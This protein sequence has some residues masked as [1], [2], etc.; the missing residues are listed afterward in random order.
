MSIEVLEFCVTDTGIPELEESG[1]AGS[2]ELTHERYGIDVTV[3]DKDGFL[4]KSADCMGWYD[5]LDGWLEAITE[6]AKK[7]LEA[8]GRG[9]SICVFSTKWE[10]RSTYY[11][12][13]WTG[14]GE[15]DTT[16]K[17]LESTDENRRCSEVCEAGVEV[18]PASRR[19][20]RDPQSRFALDSEA[21]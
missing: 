7:R 20:E 11:P 21:Q 15:W 14:P 1:L 9:A 13:N 6:I 2:F 5:T 18:A 19:S 3:A 4:S 17:L 12:A 16:W 8:I 10:I